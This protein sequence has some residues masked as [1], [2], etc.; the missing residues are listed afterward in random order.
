MA[1]FEIG[2]ATEPVAAPAMTYGLNDMGEVPL[3]AALPRP[4]PRPVPPPPDV[5][6]LLRDPTRAA[7][8]DEKYGEGSSK[9][10]LETYSTLQ[11][12]ANGFTVAREPAAVGG[13]EPPTEPAETSS[14]AAQAAGAFE[15]AARRQRRTA[16]RHLAPPAKTYDLAPGQLPSDVDPDLVAEVPGL[17]ERM[18]L[19]WHDSKFRD[20]M[21]SAAHLRALKDEATDPSKPSLAPDLERRRAARQATWEGIVADLVR[22]DGM[23][24]FRTAPEAFAALVGRAGGSITSPEGFIG[25][26]TAKGANAAWR[27]GS[28][29]WHQGFINALTDAFVQY[30]SV[31]SGVHQD[32]EWWRSATAFAVG[33]ATGGAGRY[34]IETAAQAP[35]A[36]ANRKLQRWRDSTLNK[37]WDAHYRTAQQWQDEL[38]AVN[39]RIAQETGTRFDNPGVKAREEAEKKP[40]RKRGYRGPQDV[41]DVVRGA[42]MLERPGQADVVV[43]K[44]EQHLGHRNI[45]D[46]GWKKSAA[47]YV[48]RKVMIRFS[49]GTI[50]ELQLVEPHMFS[51]KKVGDALYK[52][53]REL[54]KGDPRRAE[55]QEAERRVYEPVV[56]ASPPQWQD[57]FDSARIRE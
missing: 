5:I 33:A 57:V 48:D 14:E 20:A 53:A 42:H 22:F 50:G 8:F 2:S 21:F 10:V 36:I 31:K 4:E 30:Q 29:M 52:E 28:A 9:Q 19:N 38:A 13:T 11:T 1:E 15:G 32:Y 12:K 35:G 7:R 18:R 37:T 54:P 49:D 47:G 56:K 40:G 17:I 51:A 3:E 25:T 23:D 6:A 16:A 45:L 24:P 44:L 43:T 27:I 55:L 41:T 39:E 46:E 26:A 34:G